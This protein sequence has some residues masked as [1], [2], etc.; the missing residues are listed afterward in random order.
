HKTQSRVLGTKPKQ[1]TNYKNF[2]LCDLPSM[3]F[4]VP[5]YIDVEDKIAG[6]LT[7]RQ[8][9]WMFGMGAVLMIMWGFLDQIT[10]YIAAIPVAVIFAAL[11]F[12]RPHGQPLIKFVFH[13]IAFMFQPKIYVWRRDFAQKKKSGKVE[14]SEVG[15]LEEKKIEKEEILSENIGSL[16]KMLDSEGM[17]RNEKILEIIRKNRNKKS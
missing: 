9:L 14:I 17:E 4:N 16:A 10:F 6:P 12:Y 15:A 7:A 11:A 1:N 3:L 13:F 8:L 5:Q 2:K